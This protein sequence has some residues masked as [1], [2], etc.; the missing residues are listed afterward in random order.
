MQAQEKGLKLYLE[1]D[2]T[3]PPELTLDMQRIKQILIN[4]IGNALKFTFHG[5]IGLS[6]GVGFKDDGSPVL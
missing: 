6:A 2:P 3:L 5:F 1:C 4:L